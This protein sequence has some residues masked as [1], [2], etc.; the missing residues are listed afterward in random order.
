MTH[1]VIVGS[2]PIGLA[3]GMLLARDGREVMILE[4]DSHAAFT[5]AREAWED[6]QRS[7]VAQF[8]QAHITQP[9]RRRR[10]GIPLQMSEPEGVCYG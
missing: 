1:V 4:K 3:T 7:G 9:T 8:R 2:G 6:R 10:M 5:T